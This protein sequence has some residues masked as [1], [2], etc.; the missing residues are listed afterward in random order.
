MAERLRGRA[1]VKQRKRRLDD[2]PMCRDCGRIADV[3]DH[4]IPLARGGLDIDENC[5]PLCKEC[6]RK[7]TA[8][9]FGHKLKVGADNDG[10]PV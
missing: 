10:W 6:H 1:A 9:Q 5:R 8:E 3:I 4:I 7:R 2:D